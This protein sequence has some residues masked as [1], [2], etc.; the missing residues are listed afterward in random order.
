[1]FLDAALHALMMIS[2]FLFACARGQGQMT[3]EDH[4]EKEIKAEQMVNSAIK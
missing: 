3:N 1:M 2:C 4:M